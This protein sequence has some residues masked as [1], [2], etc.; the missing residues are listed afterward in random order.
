MENEKKEI[1]INLDPVL[2]ALSNVSINFNEEL[3]DLLMISGNQGRRFRLSPKH[4]KRVYLLL[5]K[6]VGEYETRFGEIKAELSQKKE[7]SNQENI[8]FINQ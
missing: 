6:A 1:K 7:S 5:E 4:A 2:Y 3:F 8:G